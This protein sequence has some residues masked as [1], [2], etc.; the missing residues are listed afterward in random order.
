VT[1]LHGPAPGEGPPPAYGPVERVAVLADVHGNV[2]ALRAVL[3]DVAAYAPDLVVFCGDLTWGPEP[4]ETVGLVA[5]L[6]DRA[7]L[8]RGNADRFVVGMAHGTRAAERP[9]DAWMAER[10]SAAAVAFLAAF[11]FTAVVSVAGLGDAR[12]CHGSPRSDTELVTPATPAARLAEIAAA[13]AP[14]RMLVSGHTHLQ[15]DRTVEGFRSVNAGSVGLPYH[16]GAPGTAYW[17]TLGPEVELRATRY[18]VA[19]AVAACHD[20]GDPMGGR[21][22]RMLTE[23]PTPEEVMADAEVREFA[24]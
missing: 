9:R 21:I 8:V 14:Q 15:F 11:P 16:R 22:A 7:V 1:Q 2:P 24:D 12:F 13:T 10:H 18:D 23:P 6:G 3:A 20:S 19:A 4:E 5:E 17:A